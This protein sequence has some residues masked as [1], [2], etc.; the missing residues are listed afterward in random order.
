MSRKLAKHK[1]A[2]KK[3]TKPMTEGQIKV[4][5]ETVEKLQKIWGWG[6]EETQVWL[7]HFLETQGLEIQEVKDLE[8]ERDI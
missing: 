5:D 3:K 4:F 2:K 8:F 7:M 6:K 1:K